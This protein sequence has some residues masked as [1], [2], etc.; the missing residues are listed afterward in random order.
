MVL[1]ALVSTACTT[2]APEADT[3]AVYESLLANHCC[4]D[5]TIVQEVTDTAGFASGA[6]EWSEQAE[7]GAFLP[8]VREA[9][10]DLI[11]RS[12]TVHRLPDTLRVTARDRRMSADSVRALLNQMQQHDISRLPGRETIV[13]ISG[14]GFSKDG[15]LAVVRMTEICGVL[16][17]GTKLQALRRHPGGWMPAEVVF[18][19]VF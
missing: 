12:R 14:V 6:R 13:L 18:D 10:G 5:R 1:V 9:V 19:A 3:A 16:C 8:E 17:G 2:N 11:E 15:N 7:M 4:L